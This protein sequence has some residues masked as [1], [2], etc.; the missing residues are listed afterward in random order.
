[1][2]T[3]DWQPVE[4]LSTRAVRAAFPDHRVVELEHGEELAVV[5]PEVAHV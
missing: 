5:G 1:M 4:S 3:D 2:Y